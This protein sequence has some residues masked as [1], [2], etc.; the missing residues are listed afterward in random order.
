MVSKMSHFAVFSVLYSYKSIAVQSDIHWHDTVATKH[1]WFP[2]SP[3][4]CFY[5]TWEYIKIWEDILSF[6]CTCTVY[7]CEKSL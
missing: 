6:S 4:L 1:V 7:G 2:T 3:W 5:T